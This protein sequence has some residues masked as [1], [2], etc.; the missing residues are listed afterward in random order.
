MPSS[1]LALLMVARTPLLGS[2]NAEAYQGNLR[3]YFD[4]CFLFLEVVIF[5]LTFSSSGTLLPVILCQ[6][7]HDWQCGTSVTASLSQSEGGSWA[8]S[9]SSMSEVPC[10]TDTRVSSALCLER[11]RIQL[12]IPATPVPSCISRHHVTSAAVARS[13]RRAGQTG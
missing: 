7:R 2:I 5:F 8:A 3:V 1:V 11:E 13:V 4:S 6:S 12:P 9:P 10:P